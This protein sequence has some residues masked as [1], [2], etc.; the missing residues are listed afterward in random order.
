MLC[1]IKL[2]AIKLNVIILSVIRVSIVEPNWQH[3]TKFKGFV[4][5]NILNSLALITTEKVYNNGPK[6]SQQ[7]KQKFFKVFLFIFPANFEP[8][9]AQ[10][11]RGFS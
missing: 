11:P 4:S 8:R 6:F 10:V 5:E 2:S 9:D 1:G 7:N 3:E